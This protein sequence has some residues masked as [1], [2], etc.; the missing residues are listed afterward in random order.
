MEAAAAGF[1]GLYRV[2]HSEISVLAGDAVE[3][4]HISWLAAEM[5]K[6]REKSNTTQ[7]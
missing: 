2:S 1:P 3:L 6:K 4:E 5:D 7:G